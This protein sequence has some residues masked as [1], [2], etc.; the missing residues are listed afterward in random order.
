MKKI[1]FTLTVLLFMQ[2]GEASSALSRSDAV[3]TLEAPGGSKLIT[4][5]INV[6]LYAIRNLKVRSQ[7]NRQLAYIGVAL[8]ESL[9]GGDPA[10]QSLSGQLAAY[11][12]TPAPPADGKICWQASANAA[13]AT[14]LRFFYGDNPLTLQRI[15]SMEMACKKQ[16]SLQGYSEKDIKAGAGYGLQ[17]AQGVIEWSKSDLADKASGPYT[18]P[19][20]PGLYEPTP[21][22][23]IPPIL[24]HMGNCRTLVKG[25]CDNTWAPPQIAFSEDPNSEFYKMVEAVYKTGEEKDPSKIATALF[26][27]DYPDGKTLTAAGHWESVLK[28][29]FT[30]MNT[31][32][33]EGAHIYAGLFV[34]M[35]D[36]AI[37][38]FKAKYMYNRMRP[39]TY[40]R[41]YMNH[42]DWLPVIATPPHPEYPAAHA[43]ISMAGATIL[44]YMLG[45][46]VSFTD[47]S[48]A[49]R[50]YPAHHFTNFREA[51]TEA[52]MSRFYGGIH[53]IP[54]IQA[55]FE[56]GTKIADNV[57]KSL[58]FKKELAVK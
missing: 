54:S 23:M 40:V 6:N 26:W 37:G 22:A 52:G 45:N 9:A 36:A 58:V 21:P 20:G 29:I 1:I 25:S 46:Q 43:T 38:C 8:Y 32:L 39:V 28:T 53:Y 16:L 57:A 7:Q 3:A 50:G 35:Q 55:G 51:A 14:T 5:W 18:V 11:P 13:L 24:P 27:D 4:D 44:T 17:V 19:T 34:T 2:A 31:S 33:I 48:Y 56:Q 47:D 30:Q 42:A 10:Y 49:Y 12:A 41:K 15:D